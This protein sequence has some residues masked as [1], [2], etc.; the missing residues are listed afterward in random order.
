[1]YLQSESKLLHRTT[2]KLITNAMS[3]KPK[4]SELTD[5]IASTVELEFSGLV[6]KVIQEV[7]MWCRREV[8]MLK[9][10]ERMQLIE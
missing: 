1:M 5:L 10:F 7:S 3:E 9:P 6:M 4:W 2:I 8:S